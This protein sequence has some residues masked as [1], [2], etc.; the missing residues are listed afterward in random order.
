MRELLKKVL[1]DREAVLQ[2]QEFGVAAMGNDVTSTGKD[3]VVTGIGVVAMEMVLQ[4]Q[5]FGV[6]P[7]IPFE[8]FVL[9]YFPMLHLQDLEI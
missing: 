1:R 8:I 4:Q 9:S 2:Q 7:V 3:V 5:E 6:H